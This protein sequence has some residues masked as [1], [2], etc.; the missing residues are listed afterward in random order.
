MS[1]IANIS[2]RAGAQAAAE[3]GR[4]RMIEI[5]R[6]KSFK[7]GEFT[8]ASGKTSDKYFNLKPTMMDP[9]GGALGAALLHDRTRP[10]RCDYVGGLEMGAVPL[11]SALTAIS[12]MRNAPQRAF[13][14]R[15]Q[16]KEHG[17]RAQIEGLPSEDAL[18]GKRVA[19]IEDVTTTGGSI[20]KAVEIVRE[21]GATVE[22][23]V[24]LLDRE[25]GAREALAAAGL[26]LIAVLTA[27][28]F[29][30]AS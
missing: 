16:A 6:D 12:F 9:E 29:D 22:H 27:S 7:R 24:T 17:A 23:V 13:F 25:E 11:V 28:D 10:L 21:A 2:M 19:M 4:R 8:L 15:K 26:E 20:L 3:T 5:V 18:K 14:V 30:E 1:E